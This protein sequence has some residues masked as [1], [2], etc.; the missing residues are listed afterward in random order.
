MFFPRK[1]LDYPSAEVAIGVS[2]RQKRPGFL[3]PVEGYAGLAAVAGK[4]H[5]AEK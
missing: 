1:A 2:F 3:N 5:P 4:Y